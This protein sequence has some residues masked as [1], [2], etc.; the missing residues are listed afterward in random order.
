MLCS[1]TEIAGDT[2]PELWRR[3]L[4]LALDGIKPGGSKLPV[5]ALDEASMRKAFTTHK[6]ATLV[7]LPGPD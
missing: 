5:K 1:V 4:V 6:Q 2:E 3:Y 7:N